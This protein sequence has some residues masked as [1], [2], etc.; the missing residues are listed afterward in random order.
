[1][2][3]DAQSAAPEK[4]DWRARRRELLEEQ[5]RPFEEMIASGELRVCHT[6]GVS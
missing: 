2:A 3:E 4:R 1:V 5:Q 6:K